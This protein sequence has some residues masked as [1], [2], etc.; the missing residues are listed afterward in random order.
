MTTAC[1]L[2]RPLS[3]LARSRKRRCYKVNNITLLPTIAAPLFAMVV[4]IWAA[5]PF[6]STPSPSVTA[7]TLEHLENPGPQRIRPPPEPPPHSWPPLTE[8]AR[9]N[10]PTGASAS[11]ERNWNGA[12]HD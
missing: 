2:A 12:A 4:P 11:S 8:V 5:W 7:P 3:A 6:F 10:T 9:G 1:M